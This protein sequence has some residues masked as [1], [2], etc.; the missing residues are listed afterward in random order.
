MRIVFIPARGGSKRIPS[1]NIKEFCGEPMIAW[2]IEA[3]RVSGLF[4]HIVVSTDDAEIA[5][6]SKKWGAKVPF[7]RSAELSDDY[8]GIAEVVAH[9]AQWALEQG[10]DVNAVCCIYAIAP[11]VR[12]G[13]LQRGLA[14]LESGDWSYAFTV[15]DFASP[16]FRSFKQTLEGGIGN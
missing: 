11:F 10:L 4:D 8:V 5:E 16:I 12:V 7:I 15:T 1:R 13:D 6:L 14:A 3:A 9:A 2:P